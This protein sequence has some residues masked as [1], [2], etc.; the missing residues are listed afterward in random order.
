MGCNIVVEI[1]NCFAAMIENN[2]L[3]YYTVVM[4]LIGW[5]EGELVEE[6]GTVKSMLG[7]NPRYIQHHKI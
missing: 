4:T 6:N 3:G 7:E 2:H 5:K 1:Y